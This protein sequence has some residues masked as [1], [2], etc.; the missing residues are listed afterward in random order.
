MLLVPTVGESLKIIVDRSGYPRSVSLTAVKRESTLRTTI[1]AVGFPI[2]VVISVGLSSLL[3]LVRPQPAT[4]A[5]YFY[6]V[7][8]AIKS[9]EGDLLVRSAAGMAVIHVLFEIAWSAAV[10]A[11]LFFATRIFAWSKPWRRYVEAAVIAVGIADAYVWFYP[12]VAFLFAL[13][14]S[15][16]WALLQRVLDF[17]L[18]SL[19][20]GALGVIALSSRR[21]QRQNTIWVLAGISLVP[22]LEWFDAVTYLGFY[23]QPSLHNATVVADTLDTALRPWLPILASV[24]VYYALVHERVVDIRFAIG[25]AAEYALTTAVVIVV[26]A[27]LEWAFGQLFEG[28]QVAGYASLIA[29]VVVGFSFNAVH[30]RVDHLIEAIFFFKE[31]D[32]QE[33]LLR[34]SRALLYANSERL[35]VEFLLDHPIDALELTSGAIFTLN[36]SRTAF[37][38]I[39]AK[40]WEKAALTEIAVD[41]ALVAQ[42]QA[43]QQPLDLRKAGWQVEGLPGGDKCPALAVQILMRGTVFA[44]ALYGRHISGAEI[45][46]EEQEL[47]HSVAG[48]AAAAFDHLDAERTRREI[49]ALRGENLAL[50]KLTTT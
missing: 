45:S 34:V 5:F 43:V 23:A 48:N 28:S 35:V 21:E 14:G 15:G 25:R 39:G 12:T 24:A 30:D 13:N 16:P 44:I 33:R 40:N 38:R 19:I 17:A 37:K 4:W 31:R 46:G 8:M 47:L 3:L 6:A 11:L 32:A 2:L 10:V 9:F 50:R 18:L 22:L 7:L 29:A 42:L 36:D 41:D 26:F 1:D 20:L 49:E 27:I